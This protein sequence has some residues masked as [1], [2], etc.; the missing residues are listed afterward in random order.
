MKK[1]FGWFGDWWLSVASIF[2]LAFIPLYPKLPIVD[3]RNTWVYVRAEDFVVLFVLFGWAILLVRNKVTIRT[4]LTLPI[5]LFF[6]SGAV[7]TIHS[8][9]LIA[10]T[11]YEIYPNVAFLSY[12]RRIEYMSLF[13]IAFSAVKD[14]RHLSVIVWTVV[15]TVL[16][17]SLYGIGQKYMGLPAYLTMNEEFAKGVPLTLSS[18]SRV[19]STFGGHYDLAAYL[20]L[21]IPIVVS[22]WF[23]IRSVFGKM[24]LAAVAALGTWVLFMT[25]SRISFFALF[26]AV[27][28]V[29]FLQKRKLV[30]YLIPLAVLGMVGLISFRP[31]LL[32]RFGSTV[33]K[34]DVLVEARTGHPV[35]HIKEVPNTYFENTVIWQLFYDNIGDVIAHASPSARF[36][37]S[38]KDVSSPVVLLT[39]PTAP[40]GEDLP[41]G[42]GY[43]NLT[44]SPDIKRLDHFLYEPQVKNGEE[45]EAYVINGEYIVKRAYA[46][47]LS[48]TTRFQGEWP[49]AIA[50]FKRNIFIGS[51]YG[52]VSLAVDNS[53]LRMLAEVGALGFTA[54]LAIFVLIGIYIGK[55]IPRI[56]SPLVKSFVWGYLG[57]VIGLAIN[58]LFIDVFEA[59]KVAFVLWL[60]TGSVIGVISLYQPVTV[61]FFAEMKRIATSPYAIVLYLILVVLLL[62]SPLTKNYFIGDDFTWFRW[63]ADGGS[64]TRYFTDASGFFYRPGTKV[65]FAIMYGLFWLDQSV[66]HMVSLGL[67]IGV[68]ILVFILASRLFQKRILAALCALLFV[69]LS[70][71]AEA[72]FWISSTGHL[73][74]ALL[75]LSS[76][77]LYGTWREHRGTA[78][79]LGTLGSFAL[80]LLFHEMAVVTPLLFLLYEWTLVRE[81][82]TLQGLGKRTSSWVLL[83]PLPMY[84]AA[85]YFSLSHWFSGDYNFSILKFPFNAVGNTIGYVLMALG[86]PF[87]TPVYQTL[88]TL[89]REQLIVALVAVG[90]GIALGVWLFRRFWP[91]VPHEDRNTLIFSVAFT[92]I[93]LLPFLG[94]GNIAS[95]YGYL[96]AVG[97]IFVIVHGL[98]K[99]HTKLISSGR[100]VAS[101]AVGVLVSVMVLI[102]SVGLHQLHQDWHNA[103]E[104]VKKFFITMDGSYQDYWTTMPM[105][106][107]LVNVPIRHND[108]WVFPVGISDAL[109]FVFRNPD[110]KVYTHASLEEAL[111]AVS[112]GS[113][114][115][116]VFVF[117]PDGGVTLATKPQPETP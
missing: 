41:S 44:L 82:L 108:A 81:P 49:K 26:A 48:F 69:G 80:S 70:G 92:V 12:V 67:H 23:A 112:Y 65:Y 59:S 109:W 17:V 7:A 55:T 14:K 83:L 74:A 43:I 51:G 72:V 36:K 91:R 106:F 18:L 30:L 117:D 45:K 63:A 58:A 22:V 98:D 15:L 68:S 46:Y 8:I 61:R 87:A 54:F 50:A 39:E 99:L 90:G 86:G 11:V 6:V 102:N 25:V 28:L 79:L 19:S 96:A 110:I 4:P 53:Y 27:S 9:L 115:Q 113:T 3:I 76:V 60:L 77:L 73:F 56:E 33:K 95:R 85:R 97:I 75:M 5:L 32:E 93:S 103:G 62:L 35:G 13:F 84:A 1:L 34:V 38:S 101:L 37:L 21:T 31:T 105:E 10:P 20:V 24:L 107:H 100:E 104:M 94:L 88:R 78:Y 52:S 111:S 29:V 71:F 47:D 42:T 116:K 40:T 64:M 16:S 2:L 66:Y 89:L 57:G 114:T